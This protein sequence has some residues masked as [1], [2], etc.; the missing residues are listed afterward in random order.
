MG[1]GKSQGNQP[2][3]RSNRPNRSTTIHP[4][5]STHLRLVPTRSPDELDGDG[6][7]ERQSQEDLAEVAASLEA[8]AGWRGDGYG[9]DHDWGVDDLEY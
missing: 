6:R 8:D 2:I 3:P 7:T 4:R 5:P 1:Q 9:S